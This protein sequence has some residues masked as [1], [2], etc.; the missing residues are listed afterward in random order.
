MLMK[1]LLFLFV[2][3]FFFLIFFFQESTAGNK[4]CKELTYKQVVAFHPSPSKGFSHMPG[5]IKHTIAQHYLLTHSEP[6][7]IELIIERQGSQKACNAPS[8][9]E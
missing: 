3:F 2:W 4:I 1:E 7:Q 9:G 6:H 5:N 8:L